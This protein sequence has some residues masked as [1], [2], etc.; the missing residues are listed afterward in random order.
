M[1]SKLDE[2]YTPATSQFGFQGGVLVTQALLQAEY[3]AKKV[4][5]H[6]AVLDLEKAYHKVD[7]KT[8][9]ETFA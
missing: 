5:N 1:L 2:Q 7:R 9:L 6:A 3:N 8:L 4:M